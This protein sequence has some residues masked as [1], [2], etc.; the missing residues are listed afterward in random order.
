MP[1]LPPLLLNGGPSRLARRM[2][3]NIERD[4]D[5]EDYNPSSITHGSGDDEDED[6]DE[7][8]TQ[9]EDEDEDI[10]I[11]TQFTIADERQ[12]EDEEEDK[13]EERDEDKELDDSE[14]EDDPLLFSIPIEQWRSECRK[15]LDSAM[16]EPT[17]LMSCTSQAKEYLRYWLESPQEWPIRVS[18]CLTGFITI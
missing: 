10:V 5:D 9:D 13:E 12:S 17:R 2:T 6:E 14:D 11:C 16:R 3:E 1:T 8:E 7:D 4:S 15:V 18:Q